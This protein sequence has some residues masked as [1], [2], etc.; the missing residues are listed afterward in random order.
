MLLSI[1][2]FFAF[3]QTG[4]AH[5]SKPAVASISVND[6]G[7]VNI[8]IVTN[9]EALI[10][11]LGPDH[12]PGEFAKA[13]RYAALRKMS[14]V[15][16]KQALN[17]FTGTLLNGIELRADDKLL[18]TS[19]QSSEIPDESNPEQARE[20]T[21][22][23]AAK[24]PEKAKTLSW[25]WNKGFGIIALRLNS[26]TAD[27]V[28]NAYLEPGVQSESF[29]L[30][31][32]QEKPMGEFLGA[33]PT[34]YPEWFKDSF[35][36]FADDIEEATAEGKR[37]AILFHQDGC[38][39]CNILVERNLAQQDIETLMKEK[40]DIISI[41]MWGARELISVGGK[42]YTERDFS[43][44]L[45]VQYTPTMLFFNEK[46]KLALRLNGY[47]KPAEFKRA[48]NYVAEKQETKI[49]YANYVA[50]NRV[51]SASA[52]L[53]KQS[54]FDQ[55]SLDFTMP[56]SGYE[57]PLAVFFEQTNCPN[58]DNLHQEVIKGV[59][60]NKTIRQ[61]RNA[62]LDMWSDTKVVTPE[63]KSINAKEWAKQLKINYA[64]S[65]VLFDKQGKEIIRIEAM[66]KAF[67]TESVFDYVLSEAYKTESS[68]QTYISHRA[69][70]IRETGVTVDLWK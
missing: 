37:L 61:F 1:A 43:A 53:N 30:A 60:T 51:E 42:A 62:Q 45:K 56:A 15:D 32:L 27:D 21:L 6:E 26:L 14:S 64:P 57:K 9:V 68:F 28:F 52:E 22:K 23:I 44:A 34:E 59:D 47:L 3:M 24:L 38:P 10:A 70:A 7:I 40:F 18:I 41:N 8:D 39:Y 58:C 54:F 16:L 29:E 67:H 36:E 49:S 2:Y 4:A 17:E 48:L 35:L 11:G 20:S 69:D 65:I 12:N 50:A 66:F 25:Q 46:G 63:G 55:S 31:K 5:E 13:S 33:M 19:L